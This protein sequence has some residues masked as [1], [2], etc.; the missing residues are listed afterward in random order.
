MNL[1]DISDKFIRGATDYTDASVYG[2]IRGC[3][4]YLEDKGEDITKYTLKVE[5]TSVLPSGSDSDSSIKLIL[6]A[7]LVKIEEEA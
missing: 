2:Y 5:Q 6:N 1:A 7:S 4:D 3:M